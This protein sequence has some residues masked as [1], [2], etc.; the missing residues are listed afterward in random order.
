MRK[1]LYVPSGECILFVTNE[2]IFAQTQV[3]YTPDYDQ[4]HWKSAWSETLEEVIE[5]FCLPSNES[6]TKRRHRIPTD[7]KLDPTEFEI[8]ITNE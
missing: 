2:T 5:H 3:D 1:L 8:L 7:T 6:E 4:S